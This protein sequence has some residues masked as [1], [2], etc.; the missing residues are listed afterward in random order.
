MTTVAISALRSALHVNLF[1]VSN[2]N[3][4]KDALEFI[5]QAIS[6]EVRKIILSENEEGCCNVGVFWL[7]D[8][9]E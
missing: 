8:G 2:S 5:M 1:G 4:G 7:M 9:R 6:E 3:S